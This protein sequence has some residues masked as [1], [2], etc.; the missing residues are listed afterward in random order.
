MTDESP[1]QGPGQDI[2]L[3]LTERQA[4]TLTQLVQAREQADH[5]LAVYAAAIIAG[6][7]SPGGTFVGVRAAEN[8]QPAALLLR[9]S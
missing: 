7:D 1:V 2:A 5:D 6:A 3:P 4:L 8:G 9:V